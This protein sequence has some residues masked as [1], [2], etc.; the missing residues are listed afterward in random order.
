MRLGTPMSEAESEA[1][2]PVKRAAE[3]VREVRA[4]PQPHHA[5]D[6]MEAVDE[7]K[8]A[9]AALESRLRKVEPQDANPNPRAGS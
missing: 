8:K 9:V 4:A 3:L 2:D 1:V 5:A 7:V 6:L